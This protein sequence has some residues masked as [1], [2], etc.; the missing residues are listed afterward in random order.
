MRDECIYV[1]TADQVR[2]RLGS[3]RVPEA[4]D[5]LAAIDL[6][7]ILPFERTVGDEVQ[8]LLA[9]PS[10]VLNSV[11]ALVRLGGWRIGIGVGEVETPLP[12]ST[13]EAR[14]A[15]YVA[16]REA[17]GRADSTPARLAVEMSAGLGDEQVEA[18]MDAETVLWLVAGIVEGR[19]AAAW[20]ALDLD[21]DGL[22]QAEIGR[23]LGI[24][25]S[26]VSRRLAGARQMEVRR[27]LDLATRLLGT[28]AREDV[29]G[30]RETGAD[31]TRLRARR[32]KGESG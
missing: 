17:I 20:E 27:G 18:G 30:M 16:A 4:L 28:A 5:A 6:T 32:G 21:R 13:R 8:A 10:D 29:S 31:S 3:D 7:V 23:R 15:A 1:V 12:A 25:Q 2:S 22:T 11:L 26:A 9:S 19:S 24:S 14:G